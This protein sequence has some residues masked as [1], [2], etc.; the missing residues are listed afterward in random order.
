M[1]HLFAS[2]QVSQCN[3]RVSYNLSLCFFSETLLFP[4]LCTNSS[5]LYLVICLGQSRLACSYLSCSLLAGNSQTCWSVV[6]A[7][8]VSPQHRSFDYS[9]LSSVETFT[10]CSVLNS[11]FQCFLASLLFS[12]WLA[13]CR[14]L[15]S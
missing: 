5:P 2:S 10:Y 7:V 13:T 4:L 11:L 9:N 12:H 14:L 15:D 8:F 1:M 3:W 6:L